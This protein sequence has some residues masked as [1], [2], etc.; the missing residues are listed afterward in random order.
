M[1][2]W[3][4][5]ILLVLL[6]LMVA[7]AAA[8]PAEFTAWLYT[9]DTGTMTLVDLSGEVDSFELP[10]A[11][12]YDVRPFTNV[13]VSPDGNKIAYVLGQTGTSN[14]QLMVY[15]YSSRAVVAQYPVANVAYSSIDFG[16]RFAF[17]PDSNRVA[18]GYSTDPAGWEMVVIDLVS[19]SIAG[20]IGSSDPA[21]SGFPASYGVT[22]MPTYYI[23]ADSLAFA[24]ILGGT[25][26]T[27]PAGSFV[28]NL[29]SNA[30]SPN[31][32]YG[33][34]SDVFTPTGEAVGTLADSRFG[35]TPDSFFFSQQNTVQVYDP[36]VAARWP[37][38][39]NA[40]WSMYMARFVFNG[41]QI[42]FIAYDGANERAYMLNRDGSLVGSLPVGVVP[43]DM[44]GVPD[45]FVYA[46]QDGGVPG[47]Y[48]INLRAGDTNGS[49]VWSGVP[50]TYP[51][52][53]WVG[54]LGSA[55]FM[56][57]DPPYAAWAELAERVADSEG[58]GSSSETVDILRIGGTA[59]VFTTEGDSLRVRSGP[60][61]SF[62]VLREIDPGT[63]VTLVDG[64]TSANGFVW[65]NIRLSDGLTGWVV[66]FADGEQTLIP[67][68]GGAAA[69][70][71]VAATATLGAD[72]S[73]PSQL[74][75]GDNALI[76][77]NSLRLRSVAGLGGAV[78]RE[79]TRNTYVRII[80][81]PT[82]IDNLDW[83]QLRMLDGTTGWAAEVVGTERV[84][85][86]TTSPAPTSTP[87]VLVLIPTPTPL[88]FVILTPDVPVQ[89]SPADGAVFNIFPRTTTLTWNAA[90][91]AASYDVRRQWCDGSGN[92]CNN[93]DDVNTTDTHYTFNFIGAQVG[94]W[95]VRSVSAGGI[96]S[97]WS[98]W[99][100]FRHQ[101]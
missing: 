43:Y 32:G 96:T 73:V 25:D 11:P 52:I 50:N 64:P 56:F 17:S 3:S 13:V 10:L 39:A 14:Q 38:F 9:P 49:L 21:F 68:S 85:T 26:A 57:I 69:T 59:T 23:S 46:K 76:T 7:P 33:M 97:D 47:L 45:G 91:G 55:S 101:Q 65:W 5:F 99:R 8:I 75:V 70:P 30:V 89:I 35:S 2:R 61:T 90:S 54:A 48:S 42:A 40:A 79:M 87:L 82:R 93:Y 98:P 37:V 100:T 15:N 24:L 67:S 18:F 88:I 44:A 84:I 72:P 77:T 71:V 74:R 1:R 62:I 83:W 12:P 6:S 63:V 4:L 51:R 36:T 16:G 95:R 53:T 66:E 81:G 31:V 78:V 80:G 22:P 41:R 86:F 92:N 20:G 60:G 19:F 94:R 27:T 29:V 28:W 34:A 58:G